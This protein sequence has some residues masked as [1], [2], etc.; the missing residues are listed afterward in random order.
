L[1]QGSKPA[2]KAAAKKEPKYLDEEEDIEEKESGDEEEE[3]TSA[4]RVTEAA[5]N[6]MKNTVRRADSDTPPAKV[7]KQQ[8]QKIEERLESLARMYEMKK[9]QKSKEEEDTGDTDGESK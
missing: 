5:I 3:G 9:T 2:G 7:S 1:K 8:G 4:Y 6:A